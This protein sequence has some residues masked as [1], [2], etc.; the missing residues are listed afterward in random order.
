M[1]RDGYYAGA[2]QLALIMRD[3]PWFGRSRLPI[4]Q[5]DH[6]CLAGLA[7]LWE[8]AKR[9]IPRWRSIIQ[10]H[11]ALG[12][13]TPANARQLDLLLNDDVERRKCETITNTI[14]WLNRKFGKR[15]VT[16]G[17]WAPGEFVGGKIAYNRIPSAEDFY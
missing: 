8:K 15:V 7:S 2:L 9:E 14:D 5:D 17:P 6:A 11:V 13:L 3:A 16:V 1:R 4:V 10:V 12:D